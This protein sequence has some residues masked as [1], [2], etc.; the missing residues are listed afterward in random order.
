MLF[1]Q[2][3]LFTVFFFFFFFNFVSNFITQQMMSLI[4]MKYPPLKLHIYPY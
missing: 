1:Q 3:S 2:L 4:C